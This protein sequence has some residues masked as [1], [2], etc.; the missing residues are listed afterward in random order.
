MVTSKPLEG[1]ADNLSQ[2]PKR[3]EKKSVASGRRFRFL[4]WGCAGGG[5]LIIGVT[6][7]I[8][9]SFDVMSLKLG[10]LIGATSTPQGLAGFLIGVWEWQGEDGRYSIMEF[11]P[12]GI[13]VSSDESGTYEVVS[14]YTVLINQVGYEDL[15]LRVQD[16]LG[17]T[18]TISEPGQTVR[19]YH[20]LTSVPNLAQAVIG[21]WI[22]TGENDKVAMEFQPMVQSS[23]PNLDL[24]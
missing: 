12:D 20:R 13:F 8:A 5:F 16:F 18:M 3:P 11:A 17:D 14:E 9:V 22:Y 19:T 15:A 4:L 21:L 10:P 2:Q 23:R 1:K 24:E 6:V 7:L